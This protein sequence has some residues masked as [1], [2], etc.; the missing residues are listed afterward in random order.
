MGKDLDHPISIR[1]VSNE[2]RT[3]ISG[4]EITD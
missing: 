2:P 4:P 1:V 3:L